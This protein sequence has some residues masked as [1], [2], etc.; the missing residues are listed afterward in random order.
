MHKPCISVDI[1][2]YRLNPAPFLLVVD[3][4]HH[5]R[6]TQQVKLIAHQSQLIYPL[7]LIAS[8]IDESLVEE[9]HGVEI[10]HH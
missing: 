10:P 9:R 4:V 7:N 1:P 2:N 5:E 6:S 3:D 8:I